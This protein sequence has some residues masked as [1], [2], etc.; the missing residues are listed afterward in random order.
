MCV[1]VCVSRAR[2]G[3]RHGV[4][5][6]AQPPVTLSNNVRACVR[7]E[8]HVINERVDDDAWTECMKGGWHGRTSPF[9]ILRTYIHAPIAA[10]ERTQEEVVLVVVAEGQ[11]RTSIAEGNDLVNAVK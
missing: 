4:T 11:D 2:H 8:A 3:R 10:H 6:T 9:F 7:M 5:C 1:Y